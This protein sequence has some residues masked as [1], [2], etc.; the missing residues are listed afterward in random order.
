MKSFTKKCRG[1]LWAGP[2]AEEGL[3]AVSPNGVQAA[4]VLLEVLARAG[5]MVS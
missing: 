1:C 4:C 2:R 5:G 3:E